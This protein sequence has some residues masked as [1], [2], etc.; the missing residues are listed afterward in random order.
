M[1]GSAGVS[2]AGET[3]TVARAV[4]SSMPSSVPESS[5]SPAS[6]KSAGSTSS[7]VT[8]TSFVEPSL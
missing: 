6:A 8:G 4:R 2:G 1:A 5:I 7:Q 3:V